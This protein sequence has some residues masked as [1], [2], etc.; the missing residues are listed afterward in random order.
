MSE[1]DDELGSQ[2]KRLFTRH[3]EPDADDETVDIDM[4][5]WFILMF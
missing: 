1:F 5:L 2:S 4:V 3:T